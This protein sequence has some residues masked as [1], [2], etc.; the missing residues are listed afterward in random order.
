MKK[1]GWIALC[2]VILCIA[3]AAA[4][5]FASQKPAQPSETTAT[6]ETTQPTLVVETGEPPF[7][8]Q[9][10]EATVQVTDA[11]IHYENL[12]TNDEELDAALAAMA[13]EIFRAYIPNALSLAEA[14]A[15]IRYN[16][17]L[18]AAFRVGRVY[19]AVF[20]GDYAVYDAN[21]A[22]GEEGEIFY[23]VNIDV[24]QMKLLELPDWIDA[25]AMYAAFADGKFAPAGDKAIA[26]A[27]LSQYPIEYGVYP[28]VYLTDGYFCLNITQS[29]VYTENVQYK[30]PLGAADFIRPAF[31]SAE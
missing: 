9:P 13:Q 6:A 28:Y 25:A 3:V 4:V 12:E 14:G 27:S 10:I 23:T 5:Y 30:L 11:D 29:G 1:T 8:V 26:D 22:G 31:L 21:G 2:L 19:S 24:E 18:L 20:G 15:D 7:T 17:K 16:A